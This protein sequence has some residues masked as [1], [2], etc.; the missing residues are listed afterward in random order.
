[1]SITQVI[2]DLSTAPSRA[3]PANFDSRAD[4]F[5]S[6]MEDIP[7]EVNAWATE[8]NALAV[9]VNG[10]ESAAATSVTEAEAEKTEAEA[11]A[12]ASIAA[13]SAS[14]YSGS[15]TYNYPD[16]VIGTDGHSYRC[17]VTSVVGD[18][19]VSSVSGDWIQITVELVVIKSTQLH[20]LRG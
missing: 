6:E 20:F 15:T 7:T 18:D 1:M 2:S 10:Y 3:D 17:I 13:S 11:A 5:L 12:V 8:A 16:T 9:T 14:V 4:T 19:P